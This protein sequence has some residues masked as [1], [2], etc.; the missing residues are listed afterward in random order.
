MNFETLKIIHNTIVFKT[1][2]SDQGSK[3][4]QPLKKKTGVMNYSLIEKYLSLFCAHY[5]YINRY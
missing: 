1:I 2:H 3:L 5:Y 4:A